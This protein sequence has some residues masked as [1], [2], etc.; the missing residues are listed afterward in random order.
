MCICG[1]RPIW[2]SHNDDEVN[3]RKSIIIYLTLYFNTN[4]CIIINSFIAMGEVYG[5]VPNGINSA[6]NIR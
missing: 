5:F 3:E 1:I 4:K 6:L 2:F